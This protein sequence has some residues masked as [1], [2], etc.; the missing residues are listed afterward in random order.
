MSVC[1]DTPLLQTVLFLHMRI[2]EGTTQTWLTTQ[3]LGP[4]APDQGCSGDGLTLQD[5]DRAGP[6][7]VVNSEPS[8]RARLSP[9]RVGVAGMVSSGSAP[10]LW[11]PGNKGPYSALAASAPSPPGEAAL[12]KGDG[13]TLGSASHQAL[14]GA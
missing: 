13:G 1:V 6:E 2:P 11:E 7:S 8:I 10:S 9:L 4:A 14:P 3:T 12:R 5:P